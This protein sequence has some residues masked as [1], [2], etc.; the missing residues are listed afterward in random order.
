MAWETDTPRRD[1]LPSRWTTIRA[2]VLTRDQWQCQ[3]R[4]DGCQILATEV[5]HIQPGDDHTPANLQSVCARCHATKSARE[6]A[7]GRARVQQR[8]RRTPEPHPGAL[9]RES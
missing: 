8:S 4:Y 2:G 9:P 6:G 7:E 1:R 5:D 3:L